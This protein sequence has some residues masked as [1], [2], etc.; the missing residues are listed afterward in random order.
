VITPVVQ[1]WRAHRS[2]YRPAGETIVTA[3]YEAAPIPDREAKAF[4]EQH[5]YAG[6]MPAARWC[7]GLYDPLLV[8]VAVFS[9][10]VNDRVITS[11][12]PGTARE[13]VELGRLVLL[14][15]APAN[16][17]SWFVARC[18]EHLRRE[19]LIGV[20]SFS[21][22]VMRTTLGGEVVLRGHVGTTYQALGATY[23]GRGTA[24]TL[25]L[26]PD[27]SVFSD[28]AAQKVRAGERGARYAVAQLVRA[29]AP[30]L[31]IERASE[32]ERRAWLRA[33]T[34]TVTRPLIHKGN[35][36][37]V[38]ALD[39]AAKKCLPAAQPYPK[40]TLAPANDVVLARAAA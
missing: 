26:L 18:F 23:T 15:R 29:G 39:K 14:D 40:I 34:A 38:W 11:V 3:H 30:S 22:P 21:D 33:A 32:E 8:G 36:R 16:S 31:D 27:G 35:H 2:L 7:F 6:S 19:S 1:R 37:Y 12:L 28:R 5:H 25:R 10:P 24:R 20:V 13:S 9:Y 4:V 17:E